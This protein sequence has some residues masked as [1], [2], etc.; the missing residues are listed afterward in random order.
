MKINQV[1]FFIDKIDEEIIKILIGLDEKIID[2]II[3]NFN[4]INDAQLN[5]ICIIACTNVLKLRTIEEQIKLMEDI[6]KKYISKKKRKINELNDLKSYVN[7]LKQN[8]IETF[9]KDT[10]VTDKKGRVYKLRH[11]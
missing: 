8:G 9:N 7:L 1:D 5:N 4:R 11:N 3:E 10:T 6:N 2:Y